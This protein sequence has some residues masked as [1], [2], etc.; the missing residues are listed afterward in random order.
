[1]VEVAARY[2]GRAK[3]VSCS[4]T[5]TEGFSSALDGAVTAARYPLRG[6]VACAGISRGGPAIDF[7]MDMARLLFEVNAIGT[8]ACAQ[9]VARHMKR[10][11][12]PGSIVL[13]ASMSGH[14]SN[15]VSCNLHSASASRTQSY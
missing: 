5:D 3:Y 1:M 13:V 2:G 12:V 4:I 14:I 6:L 10:Q 7:S 11:N 8:L 15:Q 9:A